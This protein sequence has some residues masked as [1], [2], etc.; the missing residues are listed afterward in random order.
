MKRPGSREATYR[1]KGIAMVSVASIPTVSQRHFFSPFRQLLTRTLGGFSRPVTSQFPRSSHPA[2]PPLIP[3]PLDT[4][5]DGRDDVKVVNRITLC[6]VDFDGQA[7]VVLIHAEA[8]YA[9]HA[10]ADLVLTDA[11]R[12]EAAA[13]ASARI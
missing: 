13:E 9:M 4:D 12:L 6:D 3:V 2:V 11:D 1:G 8:A 10:D 5:G 7:D